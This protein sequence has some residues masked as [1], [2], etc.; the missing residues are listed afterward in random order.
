[1]NNEQVSYKAGD[2][3]MHGEL[4][5]EDD[6]QDPRPCVLV[7]HAWMGQDDFARSK[8]RSLASL[9]YMGFA[10][11]L[12][13]N[14]KIARSKEEAVE[15]MTPLYK[16]RALLLSRL[17]AAFDVACQHPLIDA[18]KIGGI[19]F[20]FGGLSIIELFKSGADLR[21]VASFHAS[22]GVEGAKTLPIASGI[23]GS[24]LMLH[25]YDDPLVP[26]TD[27]LRTKKE[28]TEAHVDW[29]LHEFS[30][31]SHAFTVPE[32]HDTKMGLIYNQKSEKRSWR[33]MKNFF[34]ECFR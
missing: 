16:D 18:Q 21:G 2:T 30:N 32:A 12:Y 19:G 22:L 34:E 13:G 6:H 15:L 3:L 4:Y 14:G 25:G 8:A 26:Q 31:T 20:C 9:G 10:I 7:A 23:K 24:L 1:M 33:L 29:Q 28:L 11:D 5:Y 17:K 27:V